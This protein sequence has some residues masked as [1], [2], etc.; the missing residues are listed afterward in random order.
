MVLKLD[1]PHS[2]PLQLRTLMD[3]SR[4]SVHFKARIRVRNGKTDV[5]PKNLAEMVTLLDAGDHDL[6]ISAEGE[7]A[8]RALRSLHSLITGIPI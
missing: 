4:A 3:L 1:V 7:D 2:T 6:E 8:Y 5:N